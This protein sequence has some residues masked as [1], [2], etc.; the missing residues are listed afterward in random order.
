MVVLSIIWALSAGVYT[1][2][3]DVNSAKSFA[4]FAYKTCALTPRN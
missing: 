1:H 2:N 4:K 3:A